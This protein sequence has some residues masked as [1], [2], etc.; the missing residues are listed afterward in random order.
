MSA[1]VVPHGDDGTA[2]GLFDRFYKHKN[3]SNPKF[4]DLAFFGK[5]VFDI[6]H[7]G[8]CLNDKLMIEAGGGDSNTKTLELAIQN[9]ACVRIRPIKYR[10]DFLCVVA[11][12]GLAE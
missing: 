9:N 2:Q 12:E 4:G 5:G 3:E 7:V 11:M 10:K 6:R 8:I 1:G